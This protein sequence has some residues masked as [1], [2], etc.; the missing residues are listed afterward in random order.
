MM[1]CVSELTWQN[2]C[3]P[4]SYRC[5]GRI[6]SPLLCRL[7]LSTDPRVLLCVRGVNSRWCQGGLIQFLPW[8]KWRSPAGCA[9]PASTAA[10]SAR[11]CLWDA[12]LARPPCSSPP[13]ARALHSCTFVQPAVKTMWSG[14]HVNS[15]FK[16]GNDGGVDLPFSE[17]PLLG[18]GCSVWTPCS[19]FSSCCTPVLLSVVPDSLALVPK[20]SP[21][22]LALLSEASVQLVPTSRHSYMG[23]GSPSSLH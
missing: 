21:F 15:S 23:G 8:L 13:A 11:A 20:H 3:F 17:P 16:P 19:L 12:P 9:V 10:L 14:S 6:G 22:A 4:L 18:S 5:K 1:L 7:P 2:G